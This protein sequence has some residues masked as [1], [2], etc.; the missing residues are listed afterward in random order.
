MNA[1]PVCDDTRDDSQP[2][3][4][5]PICGNEFQPNGRG[6]FCK[7]KC[8]QKAYRLRHLQL[9]IA[10]LVDLTARLQRANTG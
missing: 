3:A 7:P 4:I 2:L 1:N 6:R 10:T 5:C 9:E 8:R